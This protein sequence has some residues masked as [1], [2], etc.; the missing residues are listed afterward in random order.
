MNKE[1]NMSTNESRSDSRSP[2]RGVGRTRTGNTG[3]SRYGSSSRAGSSRTGSSR[4]GSS[5]RSGSGNRTESGRTAGSR[6][7]GRTHD[8]YERAGR[9]GTGSS[10]GG[11]SGHNY[12]RYSRNR[13]PKKDRSI[14]YLS[15][16]LIVLVVV[17]AALLWSRRGG[18]A[19]GE[20]GE[21][22]AAGE[23]TVNTA[24]IEGDLTV[25]YSALTGESGDHVL[26]LKGMNE[27]EALKALE[28]KYTWSLKVM[29]T[30]PY[31]DSFTM[32]SLTDK[33][34]SASETGADA[35]GSVQEVQVDD[36]LANVTIR[37]SK[38]EFDVPDQVKP[39]IEKLVA[40]I[41][42]DYAKGNG[43]GSS[44]QASSAAGS[45][46]GKASSAAGSTSDQA[47]SAAGSSS[48]KADY[49]LK[50]PDFTD[51]AKDLA[52]QLAAVWDDKPKNG[53]I[54][55]YDKSSD[56]FK[57]GGSEDGY[58]F[59]KDKIGSALADAM[60]SHKYT[61][62]IQAAGDTVSG[63]AQSAKD[64]YKTISTF[65][66]KTTSNEVRN[67]NV[68]LACETVNGTVLRPGEEFSFNNV[69]GE[70]TEAKGYGAAGAYNNGE[71]VQEIGGGVCQVSSTLFNAVYRAGLTTTYRRSHT[72]EPSYVTPGMDA[73]VSWG[74]PDYR[75][76]NSSD[77]AIGIR[78]SYSSQTCTV[79]IYGVP[80][81]D[82]GVTWTMES[83][84][85][86]DLPL[87]DPEIITSGSPSA[88]T[89]G[90]V[91]E[92]YKVVKKNGEEVS[93]TLDHTTNYK[94]HR[95]KKLASSAA[96]STAAAASTAAPAPET[97]S[98]ATEPATVAPATEAPQTAAPTTTAAAKGPNDEGTKSET[99]AAAKPAAPGGGSS[100][101]VSA[102][103]AAEKGGDEA[104]AGGPGN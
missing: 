80:V 49:T 42:E 45:K 68:R 96:P 69:V 72:F 53:D 99:T 51:T 86:K 2:E 95:P 94:G 56:S 92:V 41:Y 82:D 74:G 16:L 4:Y 58:A 70:R 100:E 19:G 83:T 11:Y 40:G 55:S 35:E 3:S 76:V 73:T 5:S 44:D 87:E 37:P 81:L 103:T 10:A 39:E 85:T 61:E 63:E 97:P 9:R 66:T 48:G 104:A 101:T 28:G 8:G 84:K 27:E 6:A 13:R 43:R 47:S 34:D 26:N 98:P 67:K 14:L 33:V 30:N 29:N 21:S 17:A 20:T 62:T 23:S 12:G 90:S 60:N 77:H 7:G 59:D 50:L 54:T 25:D 79:S 52:T 93:R 1:G 18:T 46:S 88:G 36:P 65:T 31:L 57:F 91:W 22:L 78:A 89:Q 38:E 32:P 24:V 75:F 64:K 15:L 102:P 71:V